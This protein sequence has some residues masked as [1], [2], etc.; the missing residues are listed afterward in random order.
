[1]SESVIYPMVRE[2]GA[3]ISFACCIRDVVFL[4]MYLFA[5]YIYIY[6]YEEDIACFAMPQ[7]PVCV[8]VGKQCL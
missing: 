8:S 7:P 2:T 3:V 4:E 5:I 6:I 1:M